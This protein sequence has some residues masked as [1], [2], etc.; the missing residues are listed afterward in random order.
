[1]IFNSLKAG[2]QKLKN[3]FKSTRSLFSEKLR[4]LFGK[5]IDEETLKELEQTF[6]EADLGLE[7][8]KELTVKVRERSSRGL[9]P[10]QLLEETKNDILKLLNTNGK[11]VLEGKPHIIL[12]VGVNGSGKTTSIAKLAHQLSSQGK[13]V[14]LA[15]ADTFRAAA[16]DQLQHWAHVAGVELIR[17]KPSGDPSAVVFDAITAAKAR[18]V[19][20]LIIDTAG[21]LQNKDHLMKEL[22][23]IRRTCQKLVPESPHETLLTI[24]ATTGQNGIDQAKT[25]HAITPVSGLIL[26]KMDGSAK[27]GVIVPIQKKLNLSVHYIGLGEAIDD[28]QPFNAQEFVKA[29]F[30]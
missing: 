13:T 21:R 28:L 22:E 23:K 10:D 11:A 5:P 6:Y 25:F 15:A 14:L 12:V 2:F 20:V 7:V 1:M 3:V 8:A 17:G 24:D 29:L 18:G 30:E 26:T 4:G 16:V 19:D 9:N 27:G